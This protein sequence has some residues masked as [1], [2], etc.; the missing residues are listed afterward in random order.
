[1]D[2]GHKELK[3]RK[4]REKIMTGVEKVMEIRGVVVIVKGDKMKG[5]KK[6][7]GGGGEGGREGKG[8]WKVGRGSKQWSIL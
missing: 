3:G 2:E 1:M 6:D 7:R 4:R 8:V 5:R